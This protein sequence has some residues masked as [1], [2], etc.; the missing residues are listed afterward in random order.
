MTARTQPRNGLRPASVTL[1]ARFSVLRP[2]LD[3]RTALCMGGFVATGVVLF[4]TSP[5]NAH[6]SSDGSGA[7]TATVATLAAPG[8]VN[9]T[10]AGSTVD[11]SWLGVTPPEGVLDGYTVTRNNGATTSPACGTDAAVPGS[12]LP[13]GTLTCSDNAVPV[14]TYTYAVTAMFRS[15][16]ASAQS[17]SI[18]VTDST[19]ALSLASGAT[20]AH[21]AGT[22]LYYRGNAAGS[23]RVVD[24]VTA[25]APRTPVSASFPAIS[26]TGWTHEAETVTSGTGSAPTIA[27]TSSS[28]SWT[29]SPNTP[30]AHTVRGED[31][32]GGSVR[33]TVWFASDTTAPTG[34]GLVVNAAAAST[35]GTTSYARTAFS[36]GTRTD[37]AADTGS[38]LSSSILTRESATLNGDVCGTFG[39]RTVIPGAPSQSGLTT[40]CYRYTLSGTDN[41]GNTASISTIVKYDDVVPTGGAL[42]VNGTAA[43]AASTQ[44]GTNAGS[45]PIVRSDYTDANSG[46]ASSTL[47]REFATLTGATCGTFG[48]AATIVG[49]PAQTGLSTGCYRY[50]LS[51]T[52]NAGNTAAVSTIV[53][54]GAR[55]TAVALTDAAGTAGLIQPGDKI[56]ITFSDAISVASMCSAWS[57]D[58]TNQSIVAN[59][60]VTVTLNNGGAA[61]DTITVTSSTCTFNFGSIDLGSTAYTTGTSANFRGSNAN[62]STIELNVAARQLTVTLGGQSTGAAPATVAS[63]VAT[64]TPSTSVLNTNSVPFGGSF[65]TG[66]VAQF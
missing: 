5:A 39:G 35:G 20:N 41:V 2:L 63:S 40:G 36:I 4:G 8:N 38:G 64:Y 30:P 29:A 28:Y 7:G 27:Y 22:T 42:T 65:L 13:A 23:F 33:T 43:G 9:V 11:V 52:D 60:S 37:Y 15:W 6:W 31:S 26:A 32:S 66:N 17:N 14:G 21:L 44:S 1:R 46:I 51:G 12:F 24:T 54:L 57:G 34:G 62:K 18:T 48:S 53:K 56:V 61:N 45:F 10:A 58:A 47:V 59:S 19:Q 3:I 49:N 25:V 50:T 55:V 16:T